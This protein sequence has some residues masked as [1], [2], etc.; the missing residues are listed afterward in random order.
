MK[1]SYLVL[2]AFTSVSMISCVSSKKFK[3]EQARYAELSDKHN[4]LQNDL[5][6]CEDAKA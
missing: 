5:K 1:V 6:G 3:A 4:Q 2:A